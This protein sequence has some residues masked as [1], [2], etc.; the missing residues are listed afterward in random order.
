MSDPVFSI[1]DAITLSVA[2]VGAVLGILNTWK[3]IDRDRPKLRVVPKHAIPIGAVDPRLRMSIEVVNLSTFP[4]TVDEVGLL[5]HGTNKR[6]SVQQPVLFDGGAWP[7][8][9]EPR[10]GVT[11]YLDPDWIQ[12]RHKIRCAYAMTACGLTF[13]GRSPALRQIAERSRSHGSAD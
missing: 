11:A 3:A 9:L 8:R 2:S 1:K 12:F 4:L 6:A 5:Y 13:K 10:S 7:R